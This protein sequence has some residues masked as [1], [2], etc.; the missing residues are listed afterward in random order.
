MAVRSANNFGNQLQFGLLTLVT[1]QG[2]FWRLII[3]AIVYMPKKCNAG[4]SF[5]VKC[6]GSYSNEEKK[7]KTT[8]TDLNC[9]QTIIFQMPSTIK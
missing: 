1:T 9:F 6:H 3:L 5:K 4:G 7:E 2:F 8:T